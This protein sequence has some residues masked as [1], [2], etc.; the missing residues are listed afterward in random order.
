LFTKKTIQKKPLLQNFLVYKL[1]SNLLNKNCMLQEFSVIW[2]RFL[3]ASIM[4]FF[5]Q[6]DISVEIKE[7]LKTVQVLFK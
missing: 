2:H 1:Y 6:N 3:N 4:K 7:C 5:Y